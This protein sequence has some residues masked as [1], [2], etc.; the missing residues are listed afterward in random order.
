M[1]KDLRKKELRHLWAGPKTLGAS[2]PPAYGQA[3]AWQ[4]RKGTADE[5]TVPAKGMAFPFGQPRGTSWQPPALPPACNA[6]DAI[7][8]A[9][10]PA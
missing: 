10:Q 3:P 9:P 1:L 8:L 2:E 4:A 6:H 7:H 5:S